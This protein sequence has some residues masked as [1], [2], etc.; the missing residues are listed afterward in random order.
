MGLNLGEGRANPATTSKEEIEKRAE[1]PTHED[2]GKLAERPDAG[3]KQV[4]TPQP[5]A[6]PASADDGVTR[7]SSHP[8]TKYKVGRFQF[9]NGLLELRKPEDVKDFE[10]VLEQLPRSERIRLKKL[11]LS[12]AEAQVRAVKAASPHVSRAIDSASGDRGPDKPI[13]RGDLHDSN[14]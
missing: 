7:Y 12:A 4:P 13:G 3:V 14:Q 10:R 9:V 2:V 6:P 5:P 8:I 11:D 1:R